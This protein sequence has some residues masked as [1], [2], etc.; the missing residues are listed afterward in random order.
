MRQLAA[1]LR[2]ETGEGIL[3]CIKI[4]SKFDNDFEKAKMYLLS[5]PRHILDMGKLVTRR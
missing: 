5:T 2:Q 3:V 4:L 1:K